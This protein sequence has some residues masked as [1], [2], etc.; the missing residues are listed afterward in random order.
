MASSR[1]DPET[2]LLSWLLALLTAGAVAIVAL[3]TE[4]AHAKRLVG[5]KGADRLLGSAKPDRIQGR[6]G[7][8]RI[9][10]RQGRDRLSGGRGDDRI[11]AVDDRTDRLVKGGPG[12]D[13]C[14]IDAADRRRVRSC[15]IVKVKPGGG[16][17]GGG[18]GTCVVA[19]PEPRPTAAID[20]RS[21][22]AV[23]A[24]RRGDPPPPSFSDAFYATTITLNASASG[25]E[26]GQLP[27]SIE[28]VC[29]VPQALQG[30]A[31]LLAGGDAIA[32]IGPS[33]SV[34]Q[35]GA[36]LKGDAATAALADVD[37]VVISARLLRPE[38][39]GQ[40]EDGTPVPTFDAISIEITD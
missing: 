21:P 14:T 5:T 6:A 27:I 25:A 28:E 13:A 24:G 32:I 19:P 30:E 38:M 4:A 10:G 18:G 15:E 16:G 35:N 36:P 7:N 39:W 22:N 33:T 37:S 40:D 9:N 12:T 23:P 1:T 2:R 29:D 17:G 26:N 8:D 20:P 31:V 34:S 3:P 11:K